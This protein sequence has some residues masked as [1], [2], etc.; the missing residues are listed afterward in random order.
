MK[1]Q[2]L[3]HMCFLAGPPWSLMILP[4]VCF[5]TWEELLKWVQ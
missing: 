5:A 1:Q 2:D 3:A 4:Y